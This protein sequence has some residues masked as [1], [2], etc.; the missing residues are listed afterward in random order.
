MTWVALYTRVSTDRQEAENQRQQLRAFV[1]GHEGW[2]L[3]EEYR[4]EESGATGSRARFQALFEDAHQRKFEVV[5]FWAL[6]RF[7]RQ[8]TRAT[9]NYLH[10]L[11]SYGV[12][13]VS[14]TERYL[15]STGVFRDALIGLLAA[16]ANQEGIRLSDRVKAGMA[17]TRIEGKHVGRPRL[18]DRT[19][20]QVRELRAQNPDM[21]IRAI[22]RETEVPYATTRR[23]RSRLSVRFRSIVPRPPSPAANGSWAVA[24]YK[25]LDISLELVTRGLAVE[26][27]ASP[28]VLM[29][30]DQHPAKTLQGGLVSPADIAACQPDSLPLPMCRA[31]AGSSPRRINQTDL[32]RAYPQWT[33]KTRTDGDAVT[34]YARL[35]VCLARV[36]VFCRLHKS[37]LTMSYRNPR[38]PPRT[39]G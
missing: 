23:A 38:L 30:L 8:G 27:R 4:D 14:Y 28:Q 10:E 15:D 18:D 5:V 6:D 29:L 9:I 34:T 19:R 39:R 2:K 7:S 32:E 1:D 13:F 3:V 37:S 35:N 22:A 20:R 21:S 17:R 16:L 11:E 33:S 24:L 25:R 12:G 36:E 26:R 31:V